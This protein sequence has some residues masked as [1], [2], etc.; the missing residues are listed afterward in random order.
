MASITSVSFMYNGGML[1]CSLKNGTTMEY[2]M[3]AS[4]RMR[5]GENLSQIRAS[6][7][8]RATQGDG[9]GDYRHKSIAYKAD[10]PSCDNFSNAWV[11]QNFELPL[12]RALQ[13][14][15]RLEQ[16]VVR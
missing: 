1:S 7:H 6:P 14:R 15:G 2:W 11:S 10:T 4:D 12:P 3:E 16:F 8:D 13:P 9:S 5:L